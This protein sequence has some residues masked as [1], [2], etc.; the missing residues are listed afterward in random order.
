MNR[1]E[2]AATDC[3]AWFDDEWYRHSDSCPKSSATYG[4]TFTPT[5]CRVCGEYN[6]DPEMPCCCR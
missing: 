2:H 3:K 4:M 6:D 5:R 1:A